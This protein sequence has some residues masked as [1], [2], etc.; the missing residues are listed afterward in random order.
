M[1]LKMLSTVP[2][3]RPSYLPHPST[4]VRHFGLAMPKIGRSQVSSNL[5]RLAKRAILS[6]PNLRVLELDLIPSSRRET[7]SWVFTGLTAPLH[8]L[9]I[10]GRCDA[11]LARFLESQ[12]Y[13]HKISFRNAYIDPD[14]TFD[15][16][17]GALPRLRTIFS[18]LTP[19]SPVLP[20]RYTPATRDLCV[21]IIMRT[22]VTGRHMIEVAIACELPEVVLDIINALTGSACPLAL[23][24][25]IF[26]PNTE[27]PRLDV[28]IGAVA[29]CLPMLQTLII[30]GSAAIYTLVSTT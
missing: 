4:F 5:L 12:P 15:L 29:T 21:P 24:T 6:L 19:D 9:L 10:S 25:L 3:D 7:L 16:S 23:F 14:D 13:I 20:P 26:N 22:F 28:V 2:I 30:Y 27:A 17:P 18:E 11:T 8:I 1:L